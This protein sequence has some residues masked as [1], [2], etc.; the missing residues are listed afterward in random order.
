[1]TSIECISNLETGAKKYTRTHS[2]KKRI[3]PPLSL[4]FF[5]GI[6]PTSYRQFPWVFIYPYL[7]CSTSLLVS[8]FTVAHTKSAP[9]FMCVPT[10]QNISVA[11]EGNGDIFIPNS[12]CCNSLLV[13]RT[14]F[15]VAMTGSAEIF[16]SFRGGKYPK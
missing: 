14:D 8:Q 1:M 10:T 4:F 9:L 7:D 11:K 12:L 15:P 5:N 13:Q 3:H 6:P 16:V 2:S